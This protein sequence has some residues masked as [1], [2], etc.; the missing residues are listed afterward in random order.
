MKERNDKKALIIVAH[1]DDETLWAGGTILN[2][3]SWNWSIVSLT[4][5]SDQERSENFKRALNFYGAKGK[6]GD[7]DDGPDQKPLRILE[8]KT[9]I[10]S[11]LDDKKFDVILTHHPQGEYT[12]HLRHE[13]TAA[14]VIH[15]WHE[16]ILETK[17]LWLFAYEDGGR[18]YFPKAIKNNT[19][20]VKLKG[21]IW[22][23]KYH[24]ITEVYK[25]TKDS[26]ESQTTPKEESFVILK[27]PAKAIELLEQ[28]TK[29]NL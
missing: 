25:F 14:A 6:M 28:Y 21:N 10:T 16:E 18:N 11:L 17:E 1:P 13:E 7:M 22:E 4:R 27:D 20:T 15:L 8:I 23:Q 2:H 12:R 26:W 19:Y 3:L 24:L 29:I 9:V 5:K